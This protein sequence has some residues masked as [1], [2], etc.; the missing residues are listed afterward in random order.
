MFDRP[1]TVETSVH[2]SLRYD[3]SFKPFCQGCRPTIQGHQPICARITGLHLPRFPGAIVRLVSQIVIAPLNRIARAWPWTKVRVEPVKRGKPRIAD[4]NASPSI[5]CIAFTC[6]IQTTLSHVIPGII[7]R[8][9]RHA[10]GA[11]LRVFSLQTSTTPRTTRTQMS[12][13]HKTTGSTDAV[14]V[15]LCISSFIGTT[16]PHGQPIKLL[17]TQIKHDASSTA[18]GGL[19]G[20][21]FWR[22]GQL[23]RL[24]NRP[25]VYSIAQVGTA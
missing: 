24:R 21:S 7:F 16:F 19:S 1:T 6:W 8:G 25:G 4:G 23:T 20:S 11:S 2:G 12:G 17:S 18:I 13:S 9:A 22:E 3:G 15:P 14:A 5:V 10:M